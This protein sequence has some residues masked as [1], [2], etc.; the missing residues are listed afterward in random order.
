MGAAAVVSPF[1]APDS[2]ALLSQ[3][4]NSNFGAVFPAIPLV[5]LLLVI[6]A[7][8]LREFME[9]LSKEKGFDSELRT[10][11]LG[12]SVICVLVVISPITSQTIEYSAAAIVLSVYATS[13]AINPLTRKL[14]F[15]YAAICTIG[16]GAPSLL[17]WAFGGPLAAFTSSLSARMATLAGFPVTWQGTQFQLLSKSGEVISGTVTSDCSGIVSVTAF[18]GLLALM[19][20]DSKKDIRSTVE[21][22]VAGVAILLFVNS[23]RIVTLFWVG[24]ADGAAAFWSTHDWIGYALFIGVY[25]LV[26]AVY[27]RVG[28]YGTVANHSSAIPLA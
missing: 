7:L 8:R 12:L 3:E 26:L 5:A 1:V 19:H 6:V 2:L 28:T 10:R 17:Q 25:L 21:V 13:L 22:A 18:L 4:I 16:A 23:L 20:L 11:L 9:V 27:S 15:P 14:M 24:Y